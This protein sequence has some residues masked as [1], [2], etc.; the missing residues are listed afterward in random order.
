MLDMIDAV[1]M[2][3]VPL[4]VYRRIGARDQMLGNHKRL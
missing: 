1:L 4:L 3:F 2:S